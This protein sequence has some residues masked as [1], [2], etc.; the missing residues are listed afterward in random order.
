MATPPMPWHANFG[1]EPSVSG[2]T[3]WFRSTTS[4]YLDGGVSMELLLEVWD[5]NNNHLNT[6][7]DDVEASLSIFEDP[8][9]DGHTSTHS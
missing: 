1:N 5:I 8:V 4:Q 3:T 2:P 9:R 7:G 6:R